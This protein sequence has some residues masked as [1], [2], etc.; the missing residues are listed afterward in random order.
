[1]RTTAT[2]FVLAL[3]LLIAGLP[4][5]AHAQGA[6]A[7]LDEK[8]EQW[9]REE[10]ADFGEPEE[11]EDA[12][13]RRIEHSKGFIGQD[14]YHAER[15][16]Q[17]RE[18]LLGSPLA[19]DTNPILTSA[20]VDE[21]WEEVQ[22]SVNPE[23]WYRQMAA[24]KANI[25]RQSIDSWY[26]ELAECRGVCAQVVHKMWAKHMDAVSRLPH[27]Y[28][29][30]PTG[31][32]A[33]A[34]SYKVKLAEVADFL[35]RNRGFTMLVVGRASRI[36]GRAYNYDLSR[37]RAVAVQREVRANGVAVDRVEIVHLGYEPPQINDPVRRLYRLDDTSVNL[38]HPVGRAS[39]A[40]IN[41]SVVA[42]LVQGSQA[43][44]KPSWDPPT[45]GPR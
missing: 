32:D 15:A 44:T 40:A 31:S 8:I 7:A 13:G 34:E 23:E 21:V 22:M 30:Y 37:R 9:L 18:T 17:K 26:R 29:R 28:F 11:I 14:G 38:G 33:L 39:P 45:P 16:E 12:Q 35:R 2:T 36:G 1:M 3:G 5:S 25:G 6:A 24:A 10:S 27:F 43:A 20:T 19:Q 42:V 41:Q 4:G